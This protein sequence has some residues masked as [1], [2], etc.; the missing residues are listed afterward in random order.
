MYQEEFNAFS[1]K[2]KHIMFK[3]HISSRRSNI[4]I[5][6]TGIFFPI[7]LCVC[8]CAR[9]LSCVWL[10]LAPWTVAWQACFSVH[11]IFQG[12]ILEGVAISYSR[13]SS[14]LR[15]W[16]NISCVSC[17]GRHSLPLAP[18][19]LFIQLCV[20]KNVQGFQPDC[21]RHR[22]NFIRVCPK[23]TWR[24]A[25]LPLTTLELQTPW[26]P[27]FSFQGLKLFLS[28]CLPNSST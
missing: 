3:I 1:Q 27:E 23:L 21:H 22:P 13:I 4:S 25:Y 19:G 5:Y 18:P 17:I 10:F 24:R 9:M 14:W 26:R 16:T 11:G 12:R 7:Q 6:R 2:H 8:V 28:C 15:H 20:N